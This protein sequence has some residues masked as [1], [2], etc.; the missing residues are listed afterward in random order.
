MSRWLAGILCVAGMFLI[1]AGHHL[2]RSG[3]ET[4]SYTRTRGRVVRA[5]VEELPRPS[6]EGGTKFRPVVRYAFEARGR[7][8]ESERVAVGA[9]TGPDAQDAQDAR[10]LVDRYPAGAEVDVWFDPRDPGRSVLEQGVPTSQIVVA[11]VLGL[12]LVGLGT[13]ALA[14]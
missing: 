11:V 9:P 13:F 5:E 10:R 12:A 14:R 3:R 1:V 6:E 2:W 4:R 8:Y 7:A